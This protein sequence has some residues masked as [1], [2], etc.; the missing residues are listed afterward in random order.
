MY[1]GQMRMSTERISVNKKMVK[2]F[3]EVPKAAI[4]QVVPYKLGLVFVYTASVPKVENL[5]EI[6]STRVQTYFYGFYKG[7]ILAIDCNATYCA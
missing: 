4:D 7:Y 5:Q 6:Q 1:Y 2:D 3:E